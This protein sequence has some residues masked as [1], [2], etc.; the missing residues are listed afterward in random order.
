MKILFVATEC[1]P[2]I[3]TGGLGDVMGALPKALNDG[4]NDIRVIIPKFKDIKE[5]FKNDMKYLTNFKVNVGWRNQYCGV[6]ELYID[7]ITYYFLDNEYYFKRDGLYGY[8]DDGEKFAFFD[9]AVLETLRNID[10]CPDV[11]HCNDWQCGMIPA[12]HKLE[13][14]KDNFYGNMKTVF[15]IHNLLFQGVFDPCILGELFGYSMEQ[16]NNGML[17]FNGGVSFMKGGLQYA[18]K[19]TTVSKT[20]AEEVKTNWY[21]EGLDGLLREK[22]NNLYGIL[23]GIDYEEYNPETDDLIYEKFSISN[24]E[25]KYENKVALQKDLGLSVKKEIPMISIISR[26]T[27]Q[28][29][30][31]LIINIADRL[32]QNDI[33]L[34]ILGTG[35]RG[36]EEHFK[37]LKYRYNDKVS[38]NIFFDNNLAHKIYAA[39]DMFLMPSAFEPCGLSQLISLRYGTIPIVRETGGLKDTISPYNKYDITGNGFSFANYSA[40]ELINTIEESVRTYYRKS[41]WNEIIKNAMSSENSWNKSAMEYKKLYESLMI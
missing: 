22:N 5:Q 12:L 25:K 2:F 30:I 34:V 14:K 10:W 20:Y 37:G 4:N 33:Q 40:Q 1:H 17:E 36:Y 18:D 23:N 27:N 8:N 11:L 41:E 3:K 24:I 32:L 29:G 7:G 6:F 39:S 19:I 31:D 16:F 35:D 9:R 21:G 26:L 13:Y 15:S 38:T 28:K